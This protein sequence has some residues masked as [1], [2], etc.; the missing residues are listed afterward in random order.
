MQFRP[1]DSLK[2]PYYVNSAGVV[3]AAPPYVR[4]AI[5]RLNQ[6][7]AGVKAATAGVQ[8]APAQPIVNDTTAPKA[9]KGPGVVGRVRSVINGPAP[10]ASAPGPVS[11]AAGFVGRKLA[12]AGGFVARRVAPA[13]AVAESLKDAGAFTAPGE[14][15]GGSTE[16]YARRF[17]VQ[18][19]TGDG[20]VGDIAKFAALRAGGFASDLAN[21]LTGG[22]LGRTLYRDRDMPRPGE[23]Q[24]GTAQAAQA[25]PPAPGR[26]QAT[27][28]QAAEPAPAA[29]PASPA[30][31]T[32]QTGGIV[33]QRAQ[34]LPGGIIQDG[35]ASFTDGRSA[36]MPD[37]VMS[38]QNAQALDNLVAGQ[39]QAPQ[40][41]ESRM[42]ISQDVYDA[43]QRSREVASLKNAGFDRA[44]RTKIM[45]KTQPEI[46][47][48]G[49]TKGII[50]RQQRQQ[51]ALGDQELAAG[52]IKN[53][54]AG[55][56]AA[57]AQ[58]MAGLVNQ[59]LTLNNQ[60]DPAGEQRMQIHQ[61]LRALGVNRAGVE[62]TPEERYIR[63]LTK[64][65]YSDAMRSPEEAQAIIEQGMRT[66]RGGGAGASQN[67][68]LD[69]AQSETPPMEG[70]RRAPDGN[71]YVQQNGKWMKVEA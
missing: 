26:R 4:E 23:E 56:E 8:P 64:A 21:N 55:A 60:N 71:W 52:E 5:D 66:Y 38:P 30:P 51:L 65:A 18:E 47:A 70:A 28:Q 57:Q 13:L 41:F 24:A 58:S 33:G 11:R 54:V 40:D 46:L 37:R 43:R 34:A 7:A 50:R 19:P 12:G 3:D 25:Q 44:D 31:V 48:T 20:S 53:Q 68:T 16:R 2:A 22:I 59:L 63:D 61:N 35:P 45:L 62:E 67:V 9:P 6:R 17:N 10:S 15:D 32:A 39:P 36:P 49:E 42:G 69:P 1:V 14:G 29:P 27:E